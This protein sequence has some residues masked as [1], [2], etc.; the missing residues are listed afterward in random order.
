MMFSSELVNHWFYNLIN[1]KINDEILLLVLPCSNYQREGFKDSF[2]KLQTKNYELI[3]ISSIESINELEKNKNIIILGHPR[4]NIDLLNNLRRCVL[5]ASWEGAY[6]LFLSDEHIEVIRKSSIRKSI[7]EKNSYLYFFKQ[8]EPIRLLN[9]FSRRQISD[10]I[11]YS[12]IYSRKDI[13]FYFIATLL[14]DKFMHKYEGEQ[15]SSDWEEIIYKDIFYLSQSHILTSRLAI[16]IY[17][18]T[19]LQLDDSTTR[20]GRYYR[21]QLGVK[22]KTVRLPQKIYMIPENITKAYDLTEYFTHLIKL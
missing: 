7:L 19:T 11:F 12:S 2:D 6:K 8:R 17:K 22:S 1:N 5:H 9:S 16:L 14:P 18:V 21:Q 20:I 4:M 3:E 10:Y 13:P 15:Y